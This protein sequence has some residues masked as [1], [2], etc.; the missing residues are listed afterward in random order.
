MPCGIKWIARCDYVRF[1]TAV[2]HRS[3]TGEASYAVSISHS[4]YGND[5]LGPVFLVYAVSENARGVWE[6]IKLMLGAIVRGGRP[7][8]RRRAPI[9]GVAC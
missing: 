9:L 3:V 1:D 7:V 5:V 2:V 8:R 6:G 4:P